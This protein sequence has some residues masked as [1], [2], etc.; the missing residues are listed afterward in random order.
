MKTVAVTFLLLLTNVL[1][2]AQIPEQKSGIKGIIFDWMGAVIPNRDIT[3]TASDGK[4]YKTQS[5]DEGEYYLELPVGNYLIEVG[6]WGY[7]FC[8]VKL[9]NYLVTKAIMSLDIIMEVRDEKSHCSNV[10]TKFRYQRKYEKFW[11]KPLKNSEP[12]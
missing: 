12:Q 4:I 7:G 8:P 1:A 3:A 2:G 6:G 10:T 9:E 5:G 11:N